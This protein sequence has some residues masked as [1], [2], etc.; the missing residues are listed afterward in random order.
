MVS[1]KDQQG[2]QE[3]SPEN[4]LVRELVARDEY[5]LDVSFE[6]MANCLLKLCVCR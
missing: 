6:K 3:T 1:V 2:S 4:L 5:K